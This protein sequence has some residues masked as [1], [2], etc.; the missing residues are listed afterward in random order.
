MEQSECTQK[1]ENLIK[2]LSPRINL[3][4]NLK[5]QIDSIQV[6]FL[7]DEIESAFSISFPSILILDLNPFTLEKLSQ[8]VLNCV[9]NKS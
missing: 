7:L 4:A 2:A 1:L 6:A 3:K 8:V 9:N 5:D